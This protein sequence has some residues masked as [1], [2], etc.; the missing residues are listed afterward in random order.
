MRTVRRW[1]FPGAVQQADTVHA[2]HALV[3]DD[4]VD[5]VFAQLSQRLRAAA[6]IRMR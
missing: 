4:D 5:V 2:Q 1:E 6:A 3:A